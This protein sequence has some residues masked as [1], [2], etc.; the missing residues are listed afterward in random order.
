MKPWTI[1][2]SAM[3]VLL[4]VTYLFW[5][6]ADIKWVNCILIMAAVILFH[7]T[8]NVLGEYLNS[9][10]DHSGHNGLKH[11]AIC[12]WGRSNVIGDLCNLLLFALLPSLA[13]SYVAAGH[14]DW[15]VLLVALPAGLMAAGLYRAAVIRDVDTASCA[16]G[17][18]LIFSFEMYFPYLWVAL[19]SIAGL[20]PV[21]T[22]IIF[23]TLPPAIGNA[24]MVRKSLTAGTDVISDMDMKTSEV[25][26]YFSVLLSI[27][28]AVSTLI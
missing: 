27:S 28:L 13:V 14:L 15:T 20:L 4:T 11:T 23:L 10:K 3:P 12:K 8:I 2:A 22:V 6:G 21:Y 18:R 24:R 7:M 1:P 17:R 26:L 9:G 25:L 19:L 16:V 5:K